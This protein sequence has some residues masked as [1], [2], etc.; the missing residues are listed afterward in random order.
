M[1]R[2][3]CN[4][5]YAYY[6]I[7]GQEWWPEEAIT[8]EEYIEAIGKEFP[9]EAD[10]IKENKLQLIEGFR[11]YEF[12]LKQDYLEQKLEGLKSA[13]YCGGGYGEDEINSKSIEEIERLGFLLIEDK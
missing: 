5:D 6:E 13:M 1:V 12:S 9:S 3:A 7:N 2:V 8:L 4:G 10:F 11:K